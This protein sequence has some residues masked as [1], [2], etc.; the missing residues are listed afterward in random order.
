[1]DSNHRYR[2]R[3]NP[4]W[5][6]PFGPR[7]SPST[8]KTGSFVPGTDGSRSVGGG[9]RVRIHLPPAES[10]ANFHIGGLTPFFSAVTLPVVRVPSDFFCATVTTAEPDFS[11]L[12]S[13]AT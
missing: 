3:N 8:T 9:P 10:R 5:L 13:P 2:I 4:F 1:M 11:R 12:R 6:P 7:N